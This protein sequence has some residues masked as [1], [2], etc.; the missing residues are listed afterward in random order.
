MGP[1]QLD[2]LAV[3]DPTLRV[4]HLKGIRVVDGSVI[5]NIPS[6]NINI[7]IIMIAEKAADIIKADYSKLKPFEF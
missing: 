5:P 1:I 2:P 7:P 4:R 6:G 3:V